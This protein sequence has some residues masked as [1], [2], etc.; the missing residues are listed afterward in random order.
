MTKIP[1]DLDTATFASMRKMFEAGYKFV[2]I[3]G[4]FWWVKD[5]PEMAQERYE[6]L[7]ERYIT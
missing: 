7:V 5:E 6:E 4:A 3:D 1:F 2:K